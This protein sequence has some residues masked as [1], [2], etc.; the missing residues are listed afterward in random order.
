MSSITLNEFDLPLNDDA[1]VGLS[2]SDNELDFV[3]TKGGGRFNGDENPRPDP[4][5]EPNCRV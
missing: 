4:L 5:L 2:G 3:V 1:T